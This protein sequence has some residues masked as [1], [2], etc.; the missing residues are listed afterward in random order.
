MSTPKDTDVSHN[1][2]RVEIHTVDAKH[3]EGNVVQVQT[4][5]V[6]LAAA[7][8]AQKPSLLSKNMIK[9]YAI[10]SVG[11]LVSTINGFGLSSLTPTSS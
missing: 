6:A 1:E 5:S 8:A 7:L 11:Y 10:M 3:A 9:L 2:K 4:A